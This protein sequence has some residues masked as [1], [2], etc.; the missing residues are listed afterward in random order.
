MSTTL[1][2]TIAPADEACEAL[3]CLINA[4][5][6]YVLEVDAH[7]SRT[8]I[9]K[10]E[11]FKGLKVD[12]VALDEKQPAE[13]FDASDNSSHNIVVIV[14]KKLHDPPNEVP[15]LALLVRQIYLLLD[16]WNSPSNRVQ[17]WDCDLEV[18]QNPD[19]ELLLNE[20]LFWSVINLR[21]EVRR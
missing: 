21:V 6:G 11:E 12:V 18:K 9:D 16:N 5:S 7:Y 13:C 3:V 2:P 10:L 14:R 15:D 20:R 4:G 19:K 8:E 1:P 17:V